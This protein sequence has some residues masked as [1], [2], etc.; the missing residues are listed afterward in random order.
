[1]RNTE[2]IM[3]LNVDMCNALIKAIT[4]GR[5]EKQLEALEKRLQT[6]AFKHLDSGGTCFLKAYLKQKKGGKKLSTKAYEPR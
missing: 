1:M 3:I 6:L 5:T 2:D 4:A